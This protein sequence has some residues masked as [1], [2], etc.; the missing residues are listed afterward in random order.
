MMKDNN[1]AFFKMYSFKMKIISQINC[2][3][4]LTR[5]LEEQRKLIS[6]ANQGNIQLIP[7][8]NDNNTTT[9]TTTTSTPPFRHPYRITES[10]AM[11]MSELKRTQEIPKPMEKEESLSPICPEN[12]GMVVACCRSTV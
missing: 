2:Y 5:I 9:T 1:P 12:E 7:N 6:N 8:Y 10:A 3:H 11:Q 4:T